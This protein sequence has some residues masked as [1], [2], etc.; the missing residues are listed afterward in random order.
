[1]K[2]KSKAH[3]TQYRASGLVGTTPYHQYMHCLFNKTKYLKYNMNIIIISFIVVFI[4]SDINSQNIENKINYEKKTFVYKIVGQDSIKAD[5]YKITNDNMINPII[6][7]IHGGALIWGSK[8]SLPEEQLKFYLQAGYSVLSIDYRLAP[9]TKLYE[10][11]ED[12][13]DAIIWAQNNDTKLQI[14]PKK[15]FVIGHS[16]GGYLALLTGY[17]LNNPPCAIISFYGYGDI[18][19]EWANQPDSSYLNWEHVNKEKAF[20]QIQSST[21]TNASSK[22]R[23]SFYLYC[24]QQGIWAKTISGRDSVMETEYLEQFCPIKNINDNF[25]PVLLIHGDKDTDV[26]FEQSILMDKEL[27]LKNIDH[28]FIK[29]TGFDHAFDKFEGGFGNIKITNAFNEVIKFMNKYK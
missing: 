17:R 1:M 20:K 5:F 28:Q 25:P 15:V 2:K 10:I 18:Q 12:I 6:I 16:A 7:W 13:K 3:N 8:S 14:D 4:F 9:E 24:R 23:F 11:F 27:S 21:I 22:D 29:M 19:A 26:P